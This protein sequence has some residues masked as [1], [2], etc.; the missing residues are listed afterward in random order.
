MP[1]VR[2]AVRREVLTGAPSCAIGRTDLAAEFARESLGAGV[3]SRHRREASATKPTDWSDGERNAGW[4][5]MPDGRSLIIPDRWTRQ[6]YFLWR[7]RARVSSTTTN[8]ANSTGAVHTPLLRARVSELRQLSAAAAADGRPTPSL[9]NA[10]SGRLL[11]LSFP[12]SFIVRHL[13]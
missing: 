8:T 13:I 7:P 3:A 1:V 12:R 9:A 4:R 6:S 10:A 5:W 2:P 11:P